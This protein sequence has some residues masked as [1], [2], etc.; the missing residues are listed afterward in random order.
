MVRGG[1]RTYCIESWGLGRNCIQIISEENLGKRSQFTMDER[2]L[3]EGEN[4][5]ACSIH[6]KV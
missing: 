2:T 1:F 4:R 6:H 3:G 5:I